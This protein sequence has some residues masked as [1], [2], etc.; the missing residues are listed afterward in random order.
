MRSDFLR[1]ILTLYTF[2]KR[3][4]DKISYLHISTSLDNN[5]ETKSFNL[6]KN[7]RNNLNMYHESG[8]KLKLDCNS[9]VKELE[10]VTN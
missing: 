7:C 8:T 1:N 3:D 4:F 6:L 9:N 5:R 10:H 2:R